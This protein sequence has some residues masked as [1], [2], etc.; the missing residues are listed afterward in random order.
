MAGF[1]L[2]GLSI[3]LYKQVWSGAASRVIPIRSAL[4][5]KVSSYSHEIVA[6]G[7]YWSCNFNLEATREEAEDWLK[8]LA[9]HVE[10]YNEATDKIW[11]GFV[12]EV[13]ISLGTF[14]VTRG[15][16]L[17]IANKTDV[18]Y[19]T[20]SYNFNAGIVVGGDQ[21]I[22][23]TVEDSTS[24]GVYGVREKR[25]SAGTASDTEGDQL[26]QTYMDDNKDP[27]VSQQ[28][29]VGG[30]GGGS[31]S[32]EVNC[33]GYAHMLDNLPTDTAAAGTM[34]LTDKIMEVLASHPDSIFSTSTKD[35]TTNTTQVA[36]YYEADQVTMG[37]IKGMV[38]LGDS[39]NNRYTWGIYNDLTM[40]YKAASTTKISYEH[41]I[42]DSGQR[43]IDSLAGSEVQPWNIL[44][45]R[46]MII[47][48]FL[49]G[50]SL[51]GESTAAFSLITDPRVMFIESV[52]YTAPYAVQLQ[53]GRT[54]KISQQLE[55]L[56]LGGL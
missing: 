16:V 8:L 51:T 54:D 47:A 28:V 34:N 45:A 40:H 6:D 17:D 48:D 2:A 7:G 26:N 22:S 41:R 25:L 12:D 31:I 36:Q 11:E 30:S 38:A 15:P 32:V 10:V 3:S 39:S 56:S 42:T 19:Q 29:T 13:S 4:A 44:P 37:I 52:R 24:Q 14:S 27:K 49:V 50:D 5:N 21:N 46:N 23:G 55:R 18:S 20:P 35:V 9:F 33:K 53:G 1:E 43:I